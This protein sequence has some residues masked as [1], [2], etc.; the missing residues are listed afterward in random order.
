MRGSVNTPGVS[1]LKLLDIL[2]G[3][4]P[5]IEILATK[6]FNTRKIS[7]TGDVT[8]SA[9]FDGSKD[10]EISAT[11][12]KEAV[13]TKTGVVSVTLEEGREYSFTNVTSLVMACPAVNAH[14]FVTFG[15][16]ISTPVING[17]TAS[18]GDD[19][20]EAAAGEKWEFS[21]WPHNGG[22][23]IIWAKWSE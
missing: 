17:V 1:Y 7:L 12:K 21:V 22:N 10:I 18:K 23:F 20:A 16:S 3:K 19:I 15:S 8:G 4:I 6:L 9:S 11:I 2:K 13:I 14:G 5:G